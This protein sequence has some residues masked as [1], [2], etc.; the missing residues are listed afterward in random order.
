M[1]LKEIEIQRT[2]LLEQIKVMK[3]QERDMIE[4]ILK[5][6]IPSFVDLSWYDD[7]LNYFELLIEDFSISEILELDEELENW[8]FDFD[9]YDSQSK[10]RHYDLPSISVRQLRK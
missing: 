4:K 2:N 1:T 5:K 9:A 8:N 7:N 6:C 10:G 3:F